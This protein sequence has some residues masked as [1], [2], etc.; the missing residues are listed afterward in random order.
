MKLENYIADLKSHDA[1][2]GEELQSAYDKLW[3]DFETGHL[4]LEQFKPL[5]SG[6]FRELKAYSENKTTVYSDMLVKISE[7]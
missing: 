1:K 2:Y 6:L 3:N 4:T 5:M 7:S